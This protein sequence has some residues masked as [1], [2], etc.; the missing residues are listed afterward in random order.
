MNERHTWCPKKNKQGQFLY[1]LLFLFV[2]LAYLNL[3]NQNI[4]LCQITQGKWKKLHN[5]YLKFECWRLELFHFLY[6]MPTLNFSKPKRYAYACA[7]A[8]ARVRVWNSV[9]ILSLPKYPIICIFVFVYL[10]LKRVWATKRSHSL[11]FECN[12]LSSDLK[13]E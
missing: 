13:Q 1:D 12:V 4:R 3:K 11:E 9:R 5:W 6:E 7:G 2:Y 8:I 10:H